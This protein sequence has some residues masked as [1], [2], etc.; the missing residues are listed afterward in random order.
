MLVL[1]CGIQL[2]K[3]LHTHAVSLGNDKH[4]KAFTGNDNN[5]CAI[6]EYQL[7]KDADLPVI[8]PYTCSVIAQAPFSGPHLFSIFSVAFTDYFHRGPPSA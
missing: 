2:G 8:Q 1:L 5:H 6:C 4:A 3:N 7:G